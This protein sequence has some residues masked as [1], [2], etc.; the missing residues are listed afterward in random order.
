MELI[1]A[2]LTTYRAAL[3]KFLRD[4]EGQDFVE[5]ALMAG[6]VA[7]MAGAVNPAVFASVST[8]FGPII[9]AM[10]VAASQS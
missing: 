8:L 3:L 2:G 7:V 5:Y 4:C 6:F 1:N 9:S 10:N